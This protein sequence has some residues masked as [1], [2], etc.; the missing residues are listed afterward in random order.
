MRFRALR[1]AIVRIVQ[2]REMERTEIDWFLAVREKK[3][4]GHYRCSGKGSE[5]R[6]AVKSARRKE[7]GSLD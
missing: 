3:F 7:A 5:E 1:A 6:E 4:G 2:S